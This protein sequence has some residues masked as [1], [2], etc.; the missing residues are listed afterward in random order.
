[1]RSCMDSYSPEVEVV[2]F[3]STKFMIDSEVN[4]YQKHSVVDG[5]NGE[6]AFRL[7][8]MT[9]LGQISNKMWNHN[10]FLV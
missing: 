1:M 10:F 6:R 3:K 8:K 5:S 7:P 2:A 9:F 4:F